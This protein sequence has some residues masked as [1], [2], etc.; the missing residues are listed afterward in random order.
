ME[1]NLLPYP[2][3]SVVYILDAYIHHMRHGCKQGIL[4]MESDECLKN[5]KNKYMIPISRIQD[6]ISGKQDQ[7]GA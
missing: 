6:K 7:A 3:H 2:I 4:D 5:R 1:K